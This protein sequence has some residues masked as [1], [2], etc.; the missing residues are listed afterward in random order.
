M[1]LDV[2]E[3]TTVDIAAYRI[4]RILWNPKVYYRIHKCLPPVP[5]LSQLYPVRT[6]TS[7]FLKIHLNIILPSTPVSLKWSLSLRFLHQNPVY[8]SPPP[9]RATCPAHL[10]LHFITRKIF[11]ENYRSLSS[12]LCSF[13]HS[14]VSS[15]K[16]SSQH[17]VFKHPQS[18]FLPQCERPIFTPIQ[19]NRQ[20]YTLFLLSLT[21]LNIIWIVTTIISLL[22][23]LLG[24]N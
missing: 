7:H 14:L 23:R 9:I 4:L 22:L 19:S 13:L 1:K 15:P 16:Y 10:I 17:P 18:T 24:T 12:S 20:N 11:G 21:T 3:M 6:P 2:G 8:A 5:I